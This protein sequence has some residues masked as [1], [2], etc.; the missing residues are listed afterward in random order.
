MPA[1]ARPRSCSAVLV[2]DAT[3][4]QRG[5]LGCAEAPVRMAATLADG[6][7]MLAGNRDLWLRPA[8]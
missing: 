7:V 8:P 4:W 5:E 6:R 1:N 3:G 2:R